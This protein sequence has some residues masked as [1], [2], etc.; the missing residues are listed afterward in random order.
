MSYIRNSLGANETV[1][2]IAHF[3]WIHYAIAY[4]ALIISLVIS[5]IM[6][7]MNLGSNSNIWPI[8]LA[9]PLIG[10]AIF[11]IIMVP[12][13]TTEIGVTNQRIIYKTGFISRATS[14]L[15]LRSIEEVS[16]QQDIAGRIFG[17]GKIEIHGTGEEQIMLPNLGDAL[18]LR[19]ALQEAIGEVTQ[20]TQPVS[21]GASPQRAPVEG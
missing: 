4:G 14:E 17:Y 21:S 7:S 12:I 11:L 8:L 1:H 18:T 20:A 15:Q 13:W 3:H 5:V 9:P 19:K 6:A 16:M 2:Y 10:L